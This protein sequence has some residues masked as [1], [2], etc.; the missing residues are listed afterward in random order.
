MLACGCRRFRR[1]AGP[2][3]PPTPRRRATWSC[4]HR[5]VRAGR[6]RCGRPPRPRSVR[7]RSNDA[8]GGC[9]VPAEPGAH[10]RVPLV[11]VDGRTSSGPATPKTAVRRR[12]S[13]TPSAAATLSQSLPVGAQQRD[14]GRSSAIRRCCGGSWCPSPRTG[15]RPG[16][17]G[18]T[19]S[20]ARS[21]STVPAQRAQLAAS[22]AGGHRQPDQHA[23]RQV[24]RERAVRIAPP[25]RRSAGAGRAHAVRRL[26]RSSGLTAI[27]R[28]RTAR[29][30]APF[31]QKCIFRT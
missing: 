22:G 30:N 4:H 1:P 6:Q 16:R 19:L 15:C 3:P 5:C 17:S 26:G 23:P 13:S 2:P 25:A 8:V 21:R 9:H 28:Q 12:R 10:P 18:R 29:V 31:R 20:T 7:S 27:Q 14:R 24:G 11:T